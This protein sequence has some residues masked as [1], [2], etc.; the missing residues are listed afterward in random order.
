VAPKRNVFLGEMFADSTKSKN[1]L[2][3]LKYQLKNKYPSLVKN[4]TK[5]YHSAV[6]ENVRQRQHHRCQEVFNKISP[7]EIF[8]PLAGNACHHIC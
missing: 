3:N 1:I 2:L 8:L 6:L 4:F 7:Q 5:G